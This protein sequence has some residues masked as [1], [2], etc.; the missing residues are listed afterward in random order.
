MTRW[1]WRL[2]TLKDTYHVDAQWTLTGCSSTLEQRTVHATKWSLSLTEML[3]EE[4][5]THYRL[6]DGGS[7]QTVL[8]PC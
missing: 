3:L 6:A 4:K 1:C 8:I 7:L 5:R 2:S